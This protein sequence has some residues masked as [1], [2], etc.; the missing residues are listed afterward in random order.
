MSTIN[1]TIIKLIDIDLLFNVVVSCTTKT[2][3]STASACEL[4]PH[5]YE[6]II[7]ERRM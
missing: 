1:A 6:E 7:A 5:P 3:S 4:C 2:G